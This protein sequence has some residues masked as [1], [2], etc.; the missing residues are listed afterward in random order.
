[1]PYADRDCEFCGE[2]VRGH[3]YSR[4]KARRHGG[5]A[6]DDSVSVSEDS[7]VAFI[8]TDSPQRRTRTKP[9][10]N[11][12]V[13]F[14]RVCSPQRRIK[15]RPKKAATVSNDYVRDAVLCMMR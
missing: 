5:R 11:S 12:D 9:S 4:H 6:D 1:M 10:E 7:D 8:S 3:N 14:I 13:A 2:F 15:T